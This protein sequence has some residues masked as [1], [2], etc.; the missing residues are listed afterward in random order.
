[1]PP[2]QRPG[3]G[4]LGHHGRMTQ[5]PPTTLVQFLRDRYDEDERVAQV[6]TPGPWRVDSADFA[7]AIYDPKNTAVIGG[8]RWGGESPV[9]E[10]T[11]DALHIARHDPAR[12]LADVEAGRS[13]LAEY[14]AVAEMDIEDAEPEFAYGRAVGLG[15]A[16]RL[17]ALPYADHPEFREEWR[18]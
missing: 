11:E 6:A 13:L 4:A 12:V 15:I 9:F 16:V 1:M 5:T 10:T 17:R 8:G 18:P 7:E 2:E 14:E 3:G